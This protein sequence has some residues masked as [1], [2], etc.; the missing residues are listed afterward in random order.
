MSLSLSAALFNATSS[1][2]PRRVLG[3]VS[4]ELAP[5]TAPPGLE[6]QSSLQP[7]SVQVP[8]RRSPVKTKKVV[9]DDIFVTGDCDLPSRL[10]T[11][12][13]DTTTISPSSSDEEGATFWSAKTQPLASYRS[14]APARTAGVVDSSR[15]QPVSSMQTLPSV[16]SVL[17][18]SGQCKPCAWFWKPQ[19]CANG[20][21]CLHC[22][23][24]PPD[25][26]K[27]RK[28]A[29]VS[30]LRSGA[31][32]QATSKPELHSPSFETFERR[33]AD[34][35]HRLAPPGLEQVPE[36]DLTHRIAPPGFEQLPELAQRAAPLSAGAFLHGTGQ[37]RPC[38]WFW[39]PQG[40]I[41][42]VHCTHCHSC[43]P[44]ELKQRKR[45]RQVFPSSVSR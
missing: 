9:F 36:L 28:K 6:P 21:E 14:F 1:V 26:L 29:K 13:S 39:K 19:G 33:F 4:F 42:G 27:S 24:C 23:R 40:C 45:Q 30:A 25:A 22:H 43:G 12:E 44:D 37:C 10:S 16:G 3:T 35:S 18:G 2:S 8:S 32:K 41:N 15:S 38:A 5:L 7:M 34:L 31:P 11:D 20:A 17:H